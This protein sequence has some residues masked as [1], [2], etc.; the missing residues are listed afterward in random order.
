MSNTFVLEI[1]LSKWQQNQKG[2][3]F[4][5]V[6]EILPAQRLEGEV[7]MS[8]YFMSMWREEI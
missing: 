6:S 8:G 4:S 1:D 2:T 3:F 7:L 5:R